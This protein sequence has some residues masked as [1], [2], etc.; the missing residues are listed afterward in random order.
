MA[1][2]IALKHLLVWDYIDATEFRWT[3]GYSSDTEFGQYAVFSWDSGKSWRW[4]LRTKKGVEVSDDVWEFGP[5]F[6]SREDATLAADND[7]VLRQSP[8]VLSDT[9]EPQAQEEPRQTWQDKDRQNFNT[10][11]GTLTG[12]HQC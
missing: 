6:N 4:Q 8:K 11:V 10:L 7:Y 2:K 5:D 1:I 3:A 9:P 12:G